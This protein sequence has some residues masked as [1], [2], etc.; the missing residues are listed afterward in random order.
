MH[1]VSTG[2]GPPGEPGLTPAE[3]YELR[4]LTWFS[5]VGDL[6]ER[7]VGRL[8]QLIGRDRRTAVRNPRPN[9]SSPRDDE[10]STLPSLEMDRTASMTCPNCGALL[11]TKD[12]ADT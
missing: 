8:W 1:D 12:R 9:P 3:D 5:A 2:E 7:A 4:Q 6:S 11:S 10:P